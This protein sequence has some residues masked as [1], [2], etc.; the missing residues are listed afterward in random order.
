MPLS[1]FFLFF[2]RDFPY[3]NFAIKNNND[4]IVADLKKNIMFYVHAKDHF[5]KLL[6]TKVSINKVPLIEG[7]SICIVNNSIVFHIFFS[8][9]SIFFC[10]FYLLCV[11]NKIGIKMRKTN[12]FDGRRSKLRR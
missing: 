12:Y 1:N 6:V 10:F 4:V 2:S 8:K 11:L 5:D 7:S 9:I 3:L